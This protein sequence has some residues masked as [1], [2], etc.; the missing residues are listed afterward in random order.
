MIRKME[1]KE[2]L[3]ENAKI[4]EMYDAGVRCLKIEGVDG[5]L[6][7]V[8]LTKNDDCYSAWTKHTYL[9]HKLYL[10]DF[11]KLIAR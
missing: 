2:K 8:Q 3:E 9:N 10:D 5:E 1:N 7:R 4:K 6:E 11:I